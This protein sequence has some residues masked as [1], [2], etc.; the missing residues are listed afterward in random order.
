VELQEFAM[1]AGRNPE[2][3]EAHTEDNFLNIPTGM[4]SLFDMEENPNERQTNTGISDRPC[5]YPAEVGGLG[6]GWTVDSVVG[7]A[8]C[9][10]APGSGCINGD[11][12]REAQASNLFLKVADTI[13]DDKL[14]MLELVAAEPLY[15]TI[16]NTEI[17]ILSDG[18]LAYFFMD[19]DSAAGL[20]WYA[21]IVFGAGQSAQR[22]SVTLHFQSD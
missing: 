11:V 16:A 5:A 3:A 22:N 20:V 21:A 8:K 1:Q 13:T 17:G 9:G 12:A 18:R 6:F 7:N 4:I 14:T 19:L 2:T 10:Q 15:N